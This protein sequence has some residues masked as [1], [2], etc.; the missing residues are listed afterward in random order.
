LLDIYGIE[1]TL[2]TEPALLRQCGFPIY[3]VPVLH[4]SF[5][6]MR[7]SCD[8]ACLAKLS[9][10]VW[11]VAFQAF[12]LTL[13]L[14]LPEEI[15]ARN[16]E[17]EIEFRDQVHGLL[18]RQGFN[19]ALRTGTLVG[20]TRKNAFKLLPIYAPCIIQPPAVSLVH[21]TD[22]RFGCGPGMGTG[23]I[24][25]EGVVFYYD[26]NDRVVNWRLEKKLI[27]CPCL[28]SPFRELSATELLYAVTVD[29]FV[30]AVEAYGTSREYCCL[31][32]MGH[33][34]YGVLVQ[35]GK[36]ALPIGGNFYQ[37][38]GVIAYREIHTAACAVISIGLQKCRMIFSGFGGQ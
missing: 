21:L 18:A 34:N 25:V 9:N 19:K 37:M 28:G 15:K 24:P 10:L 4:G 3:R 35:E 16:I 31:I 1:Q 36:S 22:A 8:S 32:E 26:Q 2:L 27:A 6:N 30:M 29:P 12:I 7:V 14:T 20:M 38:L 17:R 23:I 11:I 33:C 5:L 13:M